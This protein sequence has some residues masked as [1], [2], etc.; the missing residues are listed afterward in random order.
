MHKAATMVAANTQL[1]LVTIALR[2]Q[3]RYSAEAFS[4]PI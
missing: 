1:S 2:G 4:G 3:R